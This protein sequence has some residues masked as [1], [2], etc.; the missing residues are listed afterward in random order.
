MCQW[1]ATRG[2][3]F[4]PFSSQDKRALHSN[5]VCFGMLLNLCFIATN[6]M[7]KKE[8]R[9]TATS[10][11]LGNDWNGEGFRDGLD[12][13]VPVLVLRSF[14]SRS[15]VHSKG[16]NSCALDQLRQAQSIFHLW[17]NSNYLA[18]YSLQL[19]LQ[20]AQATLADTPFEN[21]SHGKPSNSFMCDTDR[22]GVCKQ[23]MMCEPR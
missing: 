13:L 5:R 20:H 8:P 2:R 10:H 19:D 15:P 17:T 18:P 1:T 22:H 6:D 3:L 23:H 16:S 14:Q 4:A 12:D 21:T 7:R 9:R 11:E